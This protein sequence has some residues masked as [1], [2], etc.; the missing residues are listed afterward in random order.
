MYEFCTYFDHR[1]ASRGLALLDSLRRHCRPFRLWVLCLS[2]EC[3]ELLTRRAE[4]DVIPVSLADL[5]DGDDALLRVKPSRGIVEYYFTLTPSWPLFILARDSSVQKLT[6]LDAD[7]FFFHDPACLFDELGDNSVSI[8]PHRYARRAD[9]YLKNGIYN[10]GWLTFRRDERGVACLRWWREKCIEWCF[11]RHEDGRYA[12]QKYLDDWPERFPGVRVLGNVGANVAPWNIGQYRISREE[13]G[14][15]VDGTPLV[16]FHFH[17]LREVRPNWYD[18]NLRQYGVKP[19]PTVLDGIFEP[20]IT[21]LTR[22][23][24]LGAASSARLQGGGLGDRL[25][26]LFRAGRHQANILLRRYYHYCDGV[27][28]GLDAPR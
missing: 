11:D 3:H 1:F 12:D 24:E 14:I 18:I 15:M 8:I 28:D 20:Y 9:T 2:P 6:Y 19:T 13:D 5:E 27:F 22:Y 16:F 23:R 4:P 7:L 10:V 25:K 26:N 21:D 17:G